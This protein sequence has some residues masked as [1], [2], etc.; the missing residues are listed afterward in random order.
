MD[1]N[2]ILF[3]IL[4]V[5]CGIASTMCMTIMIWIAFIG[6]DWITWV[7]F[8]KYNEH[9]IEIIALTLST[10]YCIYILLRLYSL[11][12]EKYKKLNEGLKVLWE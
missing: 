8:N 3:L 2:K 10:A 4:F 6:G 7:Q 12:Y 1:L 9:W 5:S 11:D